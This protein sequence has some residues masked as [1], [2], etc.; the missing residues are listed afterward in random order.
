M[1]DLNPGF[2]KDQ[3]KQQTIV[4]AEIKW[5]DVLRSNVRQLAKQN[6]SWFR[7]RSAQSDW[8]IINSSSPESSVFGKVTIILNGKKTFIPYATAFLFTCI[9]SAH[10]NNE[11]EWSMSLS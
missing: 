5:P 8:S 10:V 6:Y 11:I 9:K 4:Q 1:K 2:P 3:H 7:F